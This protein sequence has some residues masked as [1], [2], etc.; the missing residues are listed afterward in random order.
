ME[1][2][3][4]LKW[5]KAEGEFV[6][7]E[8]PLLE[9][10]TDKVVMEVAAPASG[11]LLRVLRAEGIVRAGE[12]VGWLGE[13]GEE[14]ADADAVAGPTATHWATEAKP[15]VA[16]RH[17]A[18]DAV[19]RN[20]PATPAARRRASELGVALDTVVGTGPGGRITQMDVEAAARRTG[21]QPGS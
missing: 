19:S 6:S 12:V 1:E 21:E 11:T 14:I 13:R 9:M 5:L 20:A 17:A 15:A 18:P 2:A 10:E 3:N 4:I 16:Q 7:K 8:E